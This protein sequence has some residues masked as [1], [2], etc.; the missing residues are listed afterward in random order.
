LRFKRSNQQR[1]PIQATQK[2]SVEVTD[3]TGHQVVSKITELQIARLEFRIKIAGL[4]VAVKI[5]G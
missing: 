3:K 2:V 4:E 5:T 1:R